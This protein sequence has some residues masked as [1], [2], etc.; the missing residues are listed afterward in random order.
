MKTLVMRGKNVIQTT[1]LPFEAGER[2]NVQQARL[3]TLNFF[4]K[5][6]FEPSYL[7]GR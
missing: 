5:T 3:F 7:R 6:F 1:L 2:R 4:K